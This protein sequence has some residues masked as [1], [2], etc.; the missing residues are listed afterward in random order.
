MN[1]LLI[2]FLET[3]AAKSALYKVVSAISSLKWCVDHQ[4]D[5][6]ASAA[7]SYRLASRKISSRAKFRETYF[8]I[9]RIESLKSLF[10]I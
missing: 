9:S 2:G 10:I 8:I 1:W 6:Q 5:A 3:G 4:G 7:T